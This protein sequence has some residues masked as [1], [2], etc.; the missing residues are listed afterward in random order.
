[1]NK[2]KLNNMLIEAAEKSF[3]ENYQEA[4]KVLLEAEKE[5]P[6]NHLVYYNLGVLSLDTGKPEKALS[7]LEKAESIKKN[8]CDI[9]TGT[10]L[11]LQ[12]CGRKEKALLCY[13]KALALPCSQYEKAVIYNNIGSVFF[14]DGFYEKARDYFRKSLSEE[15]DY[16]EARQNLL[17]ANTYLGFIG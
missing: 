1:M 16:E 6:E 5:F 8:D 12:K 17:L 13:E 11:A 3:E 9:L 4:E 2:L 14:A 15:K 10:A 7:Y